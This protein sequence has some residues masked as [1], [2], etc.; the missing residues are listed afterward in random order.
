VKHGA[1]SGA[2]NPNNL[3]TLGTLN[4]NNLLDAAMALP[5]GIE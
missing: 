3:G 2:L 1:G 4:P 5:V